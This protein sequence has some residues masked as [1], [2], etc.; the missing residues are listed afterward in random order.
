MATK[1][2]IKKTPQFQFSVQ[3]LGR[4]LVIFD[5]ATLT[6][7]ECAAHITRAEAQKQCAVLNGTFRRQTEEPTIHER[8][9]KTGITRED[10]GEFDAACV[11]ANSRLSQSDIVRPALDRRAQR[12]LKDWQKWLPVLLKA[13]ACEVRS[14]LELMGSKRRSWPA[15]AVM[16]ATRD[17]C[18]VRFTKPALQ[19]IHGEVWPDFHPTIG[20]E[21]SAI[22]V[23]HYVSTEAAQIKAKFFQISERAYY[24]QLTDIHEALAKQLIA[25]RREYWPGL[26]RLNVDPLDDDLIEDEGAW[27]VCWDDLDDLSVV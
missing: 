17:E 22:L 16:R 24:R 1:H 9:R 14:N 15:T 8:F 6:Y 27:D 25:R 7:T 23:V 5:A 3:N 21:Q 4:Q 2:F 10:M 18:S 13:W 26:K 12:A 20:L 11:Q 19:A